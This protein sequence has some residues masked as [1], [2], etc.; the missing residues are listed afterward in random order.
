MR[1]DGCATARI[2]SMMSCERQGISC[3]QSPWSILA[4]ESAPPAEEE[5][6][7]QENHQCGRTDAGCALLRVARYWRAP[8]RVRP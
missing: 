6:E 3:A 7:L 8:S 4:R 5:E 1:A 2:D